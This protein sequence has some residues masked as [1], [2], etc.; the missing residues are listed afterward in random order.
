MNRDTNKL[1]VALEKREWVYVMRPNAYEIAAC[2]CGNDDC[3]WSEYKGHLWCQK[4]EKDFL[5]E[6]NGVFDGPIPVGV[7]TMLGMS[8]DR[9]NLATQQ[10]EPDKWEAEFKEQRNKESK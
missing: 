10:I 8:F 6:H 3:D 1:L 2:A 5:P 4:C 7:A 9:F